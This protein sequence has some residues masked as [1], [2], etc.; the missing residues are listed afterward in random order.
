ML[1][2]LRK[3][4]STKTSRNGENMASHA[5]VPVWQYCSWPVEAFGGG[6]RSLFAGVDAKD[7]RL[8]R[9]RK[10]SHRPRERERERE[11]QTVYWV[12]E[13]DRAGYCL[14]AKCQIQQGDA[15]GIITRPYSFAYFY[16]ANIFQEV[17]AVRTSEPGALVKNT[18]SPKD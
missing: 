13:A 12:G 15:S 8:V 6:R 11:K 9:I 17:T 1:H 2:R 7:Q 10:T 16:L 18:L 14:P 5:T 4:S 3:E